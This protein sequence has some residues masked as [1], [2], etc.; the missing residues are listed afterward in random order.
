MKKTTTTMMMTKK[1]ITQKINFPVANYNECVFS[2]RAMTP[3]LKS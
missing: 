3:I 2:Y 1:T